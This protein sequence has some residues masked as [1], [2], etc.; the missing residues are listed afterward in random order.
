MGA[1]AGGI[2]VSIVIVGAGLAIYVARKR[3]FE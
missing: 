2:L 3:K 1:V